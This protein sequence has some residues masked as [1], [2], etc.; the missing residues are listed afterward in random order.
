MSND[1][2]ETKHEDHDKTITIIV[3]GRPAQWTEETISFEQVVQLAKLATGRNFIY[4]VTYDRGPA[5]N[6]QGHLEADQSVKVKAGMIFHA[7]ATD[8]S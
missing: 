5:E 3:N 1:H 6:H 4:T 8:R 2:E 7:T